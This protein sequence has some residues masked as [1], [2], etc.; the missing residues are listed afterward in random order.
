MA[1]QNGR[2]EADVDLAAAGALLNEVAGGFRDRDQAFHQDLHH[3]R[4][5]QHHGGKV[6]AGLQHLG[7]HPGNI[8]RVPETDG[9]QHHAD[10][11]TQNHRLTQHAKALLDVISAEIDVTQAR[12]TVDD[13]VH[14]HGD[15]QDLHRQE[16]RHR[17]TRQAIEALHGLGAPV[18]EDQADHGD[19]G[20]S[21]KAHAERIGGRDHQRADEGKVPEVPHVHVQRAGE[22]PEQH[23]NV[24][25]NA[26]GDDPE[27]DLRAE[28]NGGRRRPAHIDDVAGDAGVRGNGLRHLAEVGPHQADDEIDA[29][30]GDAD[31]D[32]GAER[33]ARAGAQNHGNDEDDDRQQNRR[34]QSVD[35]SLQ[36][37]QQAIHV[38]FL[39]KFWPDVR[40]CPG[41]RG[42]DAACALPPGRLP[43]SPPA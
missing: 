43:H 27:A 35:D 22:A 19:D 7:D 21:G 9:A 6:D 10:D 36:P 42:L 37:R 31:G 15:G 29:D 41:R 40:A 14:G 39:P 24:H 33:L 38:F 16:M 3:A 8:I 32:T 34:A 1:D 5:Q 11:E 25:G 13:P 28:G 23:H 2:V 12:D 4:Q 20:G 30:E 17:N 18:G 26:D